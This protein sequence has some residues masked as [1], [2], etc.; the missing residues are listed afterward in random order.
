VAY[1]LVHTSGATDNRLS[2]FKKIENQLRAHASL[3]IAFVSHHRRIYYLSWAFGNRASRHL[4]GCLKTRIRIGPTL[5][6]AQTSRPFGVG[7]DEAVYARH[8]K[9]LDSL[10]TAD[11]SC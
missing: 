11:I 6:E 7:I 9:Y 2:N 8:K 4:H 1:R 5:D 10:K 3:Q